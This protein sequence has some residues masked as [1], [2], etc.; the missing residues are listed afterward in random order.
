MKETTWKTYRWMER[1]Y[2][3]FYQYVANYWL[4]D[5]ELVYNI[6]KQQTI[7]SG[8]GILGGIY[9]PRWWWLILYNKQYSRAP[10]TT[11]S[12]SAVSVIRYFQ[13]PEKFLELRKQTIQKF[14]NAR[15]WRTCRNMVKSSNPNAPRTWLIFLCPR[16]HASPQNLPPFCF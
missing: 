12:V 7:D 13:W 3:I 8:Q 14:Q 16:I 5:K 9:L 6:S 4:F 15:Q 10:V 2:R 1:R 11:D